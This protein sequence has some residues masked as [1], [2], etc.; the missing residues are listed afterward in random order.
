MLKFFRKYELQLKIL[1]VMAWLYGAVDNLFFDTSTE[2]RN[3][4]LFVGV[5]MIFL[6]IFYLVDVIELLRKRK[7][8]NNTIKNAE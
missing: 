3:F 1:A 8:R 7:P 2:N 5:I 6:A 4:D